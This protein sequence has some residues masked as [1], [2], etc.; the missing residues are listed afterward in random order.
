MTR[1]AP[2]A[3]SLGLAVVLS[4]VYTVS[5]VGE[6]C[7]F[8]SGILPFAIYGPLLL[9]TPYG[10]AGAIVMVVV[11]AT[12][13]KRGVLLNAGIVTVALVA[14]VFLAFAQAHGYAPWRSSCEF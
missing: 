3:A 9:L 12:L 7:G 11:G 13:R 8:S 5:V 6:A 2:A 10:A 4:V 14:F 1:L